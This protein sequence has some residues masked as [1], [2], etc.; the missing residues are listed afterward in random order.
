MDLMYNY[1]L[2]CCWVGAMQEADGLDGRQFDHSRE[3]ELRGDSKLRSVLGKD[4]E[5]LPEIA[6]PD[7]CVEVSH[8][9]EQSVK[10]DEVSVSAG[11]NM[12]DGYSVSALALPDPEISSVRPALENQQSMGA[13]PGSFNEEMLEVSSGSGDFGEGWKDKV[14]DHTGDRAVAEGHNH[15]HM[16]ERPLEINSVSSARG[17][18]VSSVSDLSLISL[19][20]LT[21]LIK[22]LSEEEYRFLLKSREP[23]SNVELGISNSIVMNF[24]FPEML[25]RLKEELFLTNFAKDI[26]QVQLAQQS[27]L[28][29]EFD[30]QRHLLAEKMSLLSAS[31]ND[32]CEKN[33]SLTEE[34]VDCRHEIQAVSSER[35]ELENQLHTA[36]TE[37][38]DLSAR[39]C[40][41]QNSLDRS[42][43]DL[44]SLSSEL[45][46]FKNL[47]ST[48]QV[49]KD[50]LNETII[51]VTEEK[52]RC[53]EENEKLSTDL[54]DCRSV[55][56]AL[57]VESSNLTWS[58]SSVT[59][60]NKKLERENGHQC[61][62]NDRLL[63]ELA[64]CKDMIAA[65]QLDNANIK[66]SLA[67]VTEERVKLEDD[68]K[69]SA[70]ENERLSSELLVLQEQLSTEH[71][72]QTRVEVDLKEV[73]MRLEQIMEENISLT[74]S[75]E[76]HK[77]RML[78]ANNNSIEMTTQVG[79]ADNQVENSEVRSRGEENATAGEGSH[80]ILERGGE[81]SFSL[82]KKPL[83]DSFAGHLLLG[84]EVYSDS[85]GFVTLKMHLEE[86]EKILNHLEKAIDGV[87][88][89]AA[90][91]SRAGG[92]VPAPGVSKL[93]QAFES[94]VHLD[95][96]E[97]EDRALTE[98]E[99]LEADPFML[100]K[101]QTG[102]LRALFEQ[103]VLDAAN[104]SV[105]F[106]AEQ[107]SRENTS[108]SFRGLKE[109]Y[110]ALGEHSNSL[111]ATNIELEVLY[112]AVKQHGSNIEASNNELAVLCEAVKQEVTTLKA[113][114]RELVNKLHAYESRI[115][116]F[117]SQFDDVQ[118]SSNEVASEISNQL[119]VL[120]KEVDERVLILEQNWKSTFVQIVEIIRKLDE[121][122][123]NFGLTVNKSG[124]HDSLDIISL[125]DTSVNAATKV[126]ED[127]WKK[128]EVTRTDHEAICTLYRE[129]NE[130]CDDLHRKNEL[131]VGILHK[132]HGDLRKLLTRLLRSAG[133]NEMSIENEKLLDPLDCSIYETVMV[134]LEDFLSER[135]E[136]ESD[137][138]RLKSELKKLM[139][140]FDELDKRCLN[141]NAICKLTEDV[142]GVLKPEDTEIDLD[143]SPAS[144]FESL[145][146]ILVQKYKT[147]GVQASLCR[148]EFESKGMKL[149]ELQEEIQA[150][151]AVCLQHENEVFVLKEGLNQANEALYAARSDL[152]VKVS[153]L[154]QSEQRYL[155]TREKLSI[156]VAKG[157]GLVVQRDGLKQ[158]LAETSSELERCLQ[159][160]HFKDARLHEVETKLKAYSE[161]GERVEALES[162]L[163]YIRNSATAL[164]ESFL[165]KDS[166]L[167]RIEEILEDLDLPEHFHSRDIIEKIDW[168]ARSATGNPLPLTDWDQKSSAGGG[169]YSDAG[170]VGM[171]PWKDDVQPS[172]NTGEDLKRKYE[173]LQNK[174]YGLAEQNEMLEQ[175]LMERNKMVQRWEELLNRIEM[176]SNLRSVEPE[177][178]IEWL[179][180][181][182]SEAHCDTISLQQ[183]V[184]NFENYC[185]SLSSDLEDS[186]RRISDLEA[187][188]QTVIQEKEHLSERLEILNQDHENLSSKTSQ[189]EVENRVLQ[190][191]V[192]SLQENVDELHV[193]EKRAAEFEVE[194]KVLQDE[195]TRLHDNVAE[196]LGNEKHTEGE[197]RRL[198]SLVCDALQVPGTQDQVSGASSTE[199][200]EVLLRKLLENYAT[201]SSGKTV[202][203]DAVD[204]L[205]SDVTHNE[206]RS[207]GSL[208]TGESD[209]AVLKKELEEALHELMFV[210]EE[211][212]GNVEK[213][214]NM[215]SEIETLDKKREE[216]Q[217]LLNQEEQKSASLREKLNVAVRKGKSL[218]QQRDNLKQTIEEMNAE[219]ERLKSENN[220]RETKL[221]EYE[222][223]FTDLS[224]Y[225]ERVEAL[226]SE[227]LFLRNHLTE[228]EHYLQEQ[229]NTLSMILSG[230]SDIDIGD[231]VN[232]GDPIKKLEQIA[233]L[234]VDLRS[235]MAS[236][237]QESKK[238]KRAAQLL[239]AE[240]NEVQ[241]RNDGLQEE[242]SKA[243]T[244]LAGLTKERDLAEAAKLESLSRLE[245]L[246]NVHSV[247][248]EN[249]F[250]ELVG[251]KSGI[252]QL[253]KG[254]KEINN[255]LTCVFSKD[256]EVLH[257]LEAGMDSCLKPS[258]AAYVVSVPHF[259]IS[260]GL[261]S[262]NS[263]NKVLLVSLL[264]C[265]LYCFSFSFSSILL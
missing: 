167:Q 243:S 116:E 23:V 173:E 145:V 142:E 87:H 227:I 229:G 103:L 213:Q 56:E 251:L 115:S 104:A 133:E 51:S 105:M 205:H 210:K 55:I 82:V 246:Y 174:F 64:E 214:Q 126:I 24:D 265:L 151:V 74:G 218:V 112:E 147:A 193:N 80:Q 235:D 15:Q 244:E 29:V 185:G 158:S 261:I 245:E 262:A 49:E 8:E 154:E 186:Q 259:N 188:L 95:E 236:S 144:R 128:L 189:F 222:Q 73:K 94:K 207:I 42:Q 48:L 66:G 32:V 122:V 234:C 140:E 182:L 81:V 223:K 141:S 155:S 109:Q 134:Q 201:F 162:E 11:A 38:G 221:S 230:V 3:I 255:L 181:A 47:V 192:T 91:F 258:N 75:L 203:G 249:Q 263:D 194:N 35:M 33:Q 150:L 242:L 217:L 61:C 196:M 110:E 19:S 78:E 157:K 99:S 50:N 225:P 86:A 171:E 256:L 165:L 132:M 76:M 143:T 159:E 72:E 118:N 4:A 62:E 121:S 40:E 43:G 226:E 135:L 264:V 98:S 220:I 97:A 199:C 152:Q 12:S 166:V 67:L 146:Y 190:D 25:E 90:S 232:S 16:L 153:E 20:Q 70:L 231:G 71:E 113:E 206:A 160:L 253:R 120:Q 63:I 60:E 209:I 9:V 237:E 239:L 149:A 178:R 30:H 187:D 247:E 100:I 233:K 2:I 139:G 1:I 79:E 208:Q 216:L 34:L 172:S 224:M 107:C 27:E 184:A 65:L 170:F 85:F 254:F 102:S 37:V 88:S 101:E 260:G 28:Q 68:K 180:S 204:G 131:A 136:L 18:T 69:Y 124:S 123:G 241:E 176:P 57:Q 257:N 89:Q 228:T 39:V 45:A 31:L 10:V 168:L 191:E 250:S 92:K 177:G 137:N 212:D 46:D 53:L 175:S 119:E 26:F 179:G 195:I 248:Q 108:A 22:G 127:I 93:I 44:L 17:W 77:A 36:K 59:E 156:A 14:Q 54:A 183:K 106:K 58:I 83:S 240:L 125:V 138:R 198:Q 219:M 7:T 197:I 41:L 13:Q 161:A 52:K 169:S 164:R 200:L 148:D 111:E 114:N 5:T 6:S 129:V 252:D 96:Q 202:L 215:A 117:Q 84:Q 211:R 130:N 238:S 163:S 21:D